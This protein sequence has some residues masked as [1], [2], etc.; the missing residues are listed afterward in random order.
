MS[1]IDA[2]VAVL[3]KEA[4]AD[5]QPFNEASLKDCRLFLGASPVIKKPSVYV[6]DNGNLRAVWRDAEGAQLGLQF[7]GEGEVQF[8]IFARRTEAPRIARSAGRDSVAGI[9]KQIAS[10]ELHDLVYA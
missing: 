9:R 4:R 3:R 7:L 8:V 2:R 1:E 5:G 10:F 6:I